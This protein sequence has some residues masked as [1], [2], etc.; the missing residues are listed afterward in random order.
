MNALAVSAVATLA[1]MDVSAWRSFVLDNSEADEATLAAVILQVARLRRGGQW[2]AD[3][4]EDDLRRSYE[5][6]HRL[7]PPET[8]TDHAGVHFVSPEEDARSLR[9]DLLSRLADLGTE[10]AVVALATLT[11]SYPERLTITAKLIRARVHYF[12]KVWEPPSPQDLARLFED[13]AR[14]LVR[15]EEEL[16]ALLVETLRS[17]ESD[18]P[19]H[20]E[21]LW[22]RVPRALMNAASEEHWIPKPEAALSAYLDHELTIRLVDRALAVNREVLVRPTS[23]FGAGERTDVLIEATLREGPSSVLAERLAVVVEIKGS[24]NRD[25]LTSQDTQLVA[26]YLVDAGTETGIYLVGWYPLQLWSQNVQ[27]ARRAEANRRTPEELDPH[28]ANQA[29]QIHEATGKRTIPIRIQIERP[30]PRA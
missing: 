24:W 26:R 16:A 17:I 7:F 9:D 22:D 3:A 30:A 27:D 20:C 11:R 28:L 8:D 2:W 1:V 25:L 21:L 10:A 29:K 14:R 13:A 15:S 12:A 23:A 6:L 5:L 18:L 4:T 19:G